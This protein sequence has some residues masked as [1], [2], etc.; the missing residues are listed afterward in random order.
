MD[1]LNTQII[2]RNK[3]NID[4]NEL[5]LLEVLLIAQEE[6]DNE[7][8]KLYFTSTKNIRTN[9][10]A[11]KDAG[12][13]LKSYKIPEKG[14]HLDIYAIPINKNVTKDFYKSSFEM[15]KELFDTYPQFTTIN[16]NVVGI[17][18]VSKKFNSLEDFYRFYGKSIRNK[19]ELHKYILDLIEWGKEH[20]VIATTLANFVID[21]K[22]TEL[23]AL[24]D[25][26]IA[27]V[28]YDAVKIV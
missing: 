7:L 8:V 23:Q 1:S 3:Y 21:Q 26:D 24:K 4:D 17:R 18:S 25:G 27:N 20:D 19:P 14:E 22:W 2:F 15:G 13:I 9:L 6:E 16:N 28:N 11:L 5:T 12:I 10:I